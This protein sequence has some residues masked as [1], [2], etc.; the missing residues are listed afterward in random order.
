M[1]QPLG[2]GVVERQA[3]FAEDR[4][5]PL[6]GELLLAGEEVAERLAR[7]VLHDEVEHATRLAGGIDRDDV[8]VAQ[9]GDGAGLLEEPLAERDVA[10]H[11]GVDDLDRD[12][13]VEGGVARQVDRPHPALAEQALDGVLRTEGGAQGVQGGGWG[14]RGVGQAAA[15]RSVVDGA[16]GCRPRRMDRSSIDRAARGG[17]HV[18]GD[19]SAATG[20]GKGLLVLRAGLLVQCPH[21]R[22]RQVIELADSRG[23]DKGGNANPNQHQGQRQ[24]QVEDAHATP[25]DPL[26]RRP[27]DPLKLRLRHECR[28]TVNELIGIRI[29]ATRGSSSPAMA[30]PAPTRL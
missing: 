28:I 1:D 14:F 11:V 15:Q 25:P 9:L 5:H 6:A 20:V 16:V 30:S 26:T 8:G 21:P 3:E 27:A 22:R 18:A 12:W 29:A 23:P 13:A 2:M 10:R 24:H 4:R 7:H 17:Q 19:C